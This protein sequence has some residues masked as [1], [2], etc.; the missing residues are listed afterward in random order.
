MVA[1]KSI[2]PVIDTRKIGG[3]DVAAIHGMSRYRGPHS[4]YLRVVEGLQE[5]QTEPQ[6]YGHDAE[7]GI[8]AFAFRRLGGEWRRS[9][10][11][12]VPQ[13]FLRCN[14]DALSVDGRTVIDAKNSARGEGYGAPGGDAVPDDVL[15]QQHY[16]CFVTGAERA[17]VAA[18]IGGRP[19]ELYY[20]ER[21]ED[22]GARLL[23][24]MIAFWREHIE[25]RVPPPLDFADP[26]VGEYLARKHARPT[27]II[28]PA[29]AI[30]ERL[31][32]DYAAAKAELEAADQA[33]SALRAQLQ[34]AIG[35]D[36]GVES[37]SLG[38][39]AW[40]SVKDSLGP[41]W[42][43]IAGRLADAATVDALA[44]DV[45]RVVRKGHRR[46]EARLNAPG[47]E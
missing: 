37:P 32:R 27:E 12:A 11:H 16:Y 8:L 31:M 9:V 1:A 41:D 25:P 22:F 29:T 13:P 30:E 45:Q 42:E 24:G 47:E 15:M 35:D 46:F 19:P 4:V 14:L 44:K 7:P 2:A 20:I 18:S 23:R 10:Q 43:G 26:F 38:R 28:R 17:V 33:C 36:R 39:V 5:A 6:E 34:A 3:S 21:D 40:T